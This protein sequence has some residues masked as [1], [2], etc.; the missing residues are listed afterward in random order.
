M[1]PTLDE[2]LNPNEPIGGQA[3]SIEFIGG[4]GIIVAPGPALLANMS[5]YGYGVIDLKPIG[6]LQGLDVNT[7]KRVN[8]TS[9]LGTHARYNTTSRGDKV[10]A[11]PRIITKQ[12]NLLKAMYNFLLDVEHGENSDE[13][14]TVETGDYPYG[15]IWKNIDHPLFKKPTGLLI[16][17]MNGK[18]ELLMLAYLENVLIQQMSDVV[19]EG[20]R[21]LAENV[22]IKWAKTRYL[23]IT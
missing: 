11:I 17:M 2:S 14:W 10:I 7:F 6:L 1:V 15:N 18:R 20:Q 13:P 4:D 9:E 5:T 8:K 21:G 19:A 16:E 22:V 23:P 12:S 3:N